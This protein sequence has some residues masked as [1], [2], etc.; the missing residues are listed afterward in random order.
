MDTEKKQNSLWSFF[1]PHYDELSL[2]IIVYVILLLFFFHN[3]PSDWTFSHFNAES[4]DIKLSLLIFFPLI[5]GMCLCLY[6]AFTDR[7]KTNI[8]KKFMIFF[9]AIINGFI[10]LWYGTYILV[11]NAGWGLSLFPVWNVISGYFLIG[12]LRTPDIEGICISDENVSLQ[13]LLLGTIVSVN[14]TAPFHTD[15]ISHEDPQKSLK[16]ANCLVT[17]I[18]N[19][20]P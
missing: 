15:E 10:G 4:T 6:H 2:F 17:K 18:H 12:S 7:K 5:I 13:K 3:P 16:I 14:L 9:A 1:T 20:Q 11:N 8:E 19:F